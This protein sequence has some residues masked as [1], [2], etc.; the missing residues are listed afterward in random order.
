LK[1]IKNSRVVIC[2][3]ARPLVTPDQIKR[4]ASVDYPSVSYAFPSVDTIFYKNRHLDR[5]S[6][7]QLQ[8]PQSFDRDM[9]LES[10]RNSI[11]RDSTSDTFLIQD[12]FGVK[13]RLILG[14]RNLFKVTYPGDIEYLDILEDLFCQKK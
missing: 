13:P 8:L 14:G 3:A 7:F 5:M 9:L 10:H 4:I 11:F 12:Y 6:S 1:K 2:E